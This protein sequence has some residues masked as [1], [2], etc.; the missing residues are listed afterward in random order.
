[1]FSSARF[2]AIYAGVV[3][4]VLVGTLVIGASILRTDEFGTINIRDPIARRLRASC[5]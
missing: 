1:M 4:L 2:W 5:S 3:T